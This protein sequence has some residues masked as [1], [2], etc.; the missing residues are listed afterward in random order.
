MDASDSP[1]FSR[2]REAAWSSA[3]RTLPR[4]VARDC[5]AIIVSPL[6]Q[7]MA[8]NPI[9]YSLSSAEIVPTSMAL[10]PARWQSSRAVSPVT[11]SSPERPI[12]RSVDATL[13]SEM[14]FRRGD[15]SR[16]KISACF[17][18]SNTASPVFVGE[19]GDDDGVLFRNHLACG[20]KI[21]T[22][23]D[24]KDQGATGCKQ[25]S[26]GSPGAVTSGNAFLPRNFCC[27]W[28]GCGSVHGDFSS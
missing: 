3:A 6:T 24:G 8:C 2:L 19:I 12:N 17:K 13:R 27:D 14:M 28:R 20:N 5:S 11:R 26:P 9:R 7:L 25:Q 15:C 1:S 18:A 10:L 21:D 23:G 22:S 16:S 4:P